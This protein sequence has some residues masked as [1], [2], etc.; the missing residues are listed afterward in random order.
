MKR[1]VPILVLLFCASTGHAADATAPLPATIRL[2]LA[3]ALEKAKAVSPRLAQ[4]TSLESAASAAARGARAERL[5]EVSASAGYARNS[6]VPEFTLA[7]PGAPP[8]TI[9][10]NIPDNYRFHAGVALPLFTSGRLENG[11]AAADEQRRAAARDR[12][13]GL[14]DV[15]LETTA[16][17]WALVDSRE[18]VKVLTEA[19]DGYEA[20]LKDAQARQEV[21]MA[22]RNEVL[23]VQ[24]E[25][26]RAELARLQAQ[27]LVAT[28]E[29]NLRRLLALPP[30]TQV[31]CTEPLER[32]PAAPEDVE[33]LVAQATASRPELDGIQARAAAL[34]AS[35]KAQR[36]A[37]LPQVSLAAGYDY[38]N[39][40]TR[41]LPPS[42]DW[43]GSWSVGVNL[44]V[45]PFDGGRAAAAA[46][47]ARARADAVRHDLEDLRARIRLDVTSRALDLSTSR[48]SID[49]A[50]R[51]LEAARE[52]VRVARARYKEGV[53]SS[54]ELLDAETALLRAGLDLTASLTG[55]R[56]AEARLDRAVGR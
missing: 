14:G 5:P 42:A 15:V 23:A 40:N 47:Q 8:R 13:A 33:A 48:A 1:L 39:P 29:A 26:D 41:I 19:M 11:I 50:E 34:D 16:V 54:S 43:K 4:L 7:L 21:G 20:H 31:E 28:A 46:A 35:A 12:E 18:S 27:N 3:D 6:N 10:P 37:V 45:T 9:F 2:G 17:Y 32:R 24:V 51:S 36:A 25:R 49:L 52:N 30:G 22:A 55:Q 38:A 53:I 44:A 56:V